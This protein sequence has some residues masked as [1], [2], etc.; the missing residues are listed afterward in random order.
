MTGP[1]VDPSIL[2]ELFVKL[3][4][5]QVEIKNHLCKD[6]AEMDNPEKRTEVLLDL[7]LDPVII[8][9]FL[10]GDMILSDETQIAVLMELWGSDAKR[11]LLEVNELIG[12]VY[13]GMLPIALLSEQQLALFFDIHDLRYNNRQLLSVVDF[14]ELFG[15]HK[16]LVG[17]ILRYK[18]ESFMSLRVP[19]T[20]VEIYNHLFEVKREGISNVVKRMSET[21]AIV[22]PQQSPAT[23]PKSVRISSRS[24]KK[25]TKLPTELQQLIEE[26]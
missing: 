10:D 24:K 21:A 19:E 25:A 14:C 7:G 22:S 17:G 9:P 18:R 3:S 2:K 1:K 8:T 26:V 5:A 11:T 15:P 16:D 13:K 6:I 23:T 20:Y 4:K 12:R